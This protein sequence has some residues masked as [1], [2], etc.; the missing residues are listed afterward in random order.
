VPDAEK[1][2]Q[3]KKLASSVVLG[4]SLLGL[5]EAT[6]QKEMTGIPL[7]GGKRNQP[8]FG[9][10]PG[11]EADLDA[12]L[13]SDSL[14]KGFQEHKQPLSETVSVH[15]I[16]AGRVW[17]ID[18]EHKRYL[19]RKDDDAVNVYPVL[20]RRRMAYLLPF[21][22][23]SVHLLVVLIGAAYLARAKRRVTRA[24]TMTG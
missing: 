19:V 9:V 20:V 12:G 18:T 3:P 16:E 22:I 4:E 23:V 10:P 7:G 5:T 15:A 24:D 1:L 2:S 21:E 11:P 6:P 17:Q 13:V 14:R 8:L